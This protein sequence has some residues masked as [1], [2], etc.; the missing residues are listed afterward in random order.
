MQEEKS[1]QTAAQEVLSIVRSRFKQFVTWLKPSPGEHWSLQALKLLAKIP[2]VLL[3]VA[4][5]PLLLVVMLLV[6]LIAL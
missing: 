4:L 2:V 3:A 6:F 1:K 5:S